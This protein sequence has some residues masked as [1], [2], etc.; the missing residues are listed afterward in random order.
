MLRIAVCDDEQAYLDKTCAMLEQYAA[1]NKLEY[2]P[3]AFSN[4]SV[5]LDCIEEGLRHDIY[6]LDIYMPGVS[7]MSIAT[8]LRAIGVQ[9][10]VI[11]LTSS[12]DHAVEAF[13]VDATHYM[14]K[15]YTRQSFFAAMDKAVRNICDHP[16]ESIVL[17]VDNEY[18]NIVVS[19]ILYCEANDKYQRLC[20]ETGEKVLI[21]M[22]GSDLYEKLKAFGCFYRCGRAHIINLAQ[23]KKVT[24]ASAILR[25]GTEIPLPRTAVAGLRT[26][27]FDYFK[28]GGTIV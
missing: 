7:G 16:E 15:P 19:K 6:L 4:A 14:L 3:E 13:G 10:P 25:D 2:T 21:R 26:A 23:I 5:L 28:A 8:E 27:F 20:L 18:Q 12:V 22:T 11:F 1:E 17:K 24:P 9:S